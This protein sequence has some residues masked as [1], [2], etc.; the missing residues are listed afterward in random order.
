MPTAETD[1][2]RGRER[3][4][5]LAREDTFGQAPP[6]PDWR[7][8]PLAPKGW[9]VH[10]ERRWF[11]PGTPQDVALPG[12]MS[13]RGLFRAAPFPQTTGF[14]LDAALERPSPEELHSHTADCLTPAGSRRYTG[15]TVETLVLSVNGAGARVGLRFRGRSVS[16]NISLARSDFDYTDLT[17][18]PFSL[19]DAQL[20]INGAKAAAVSGFTLRADNDLV[21][22]PNEGRRTAY[23]LAR[24][25]TLTLALEGL[26]GG[27]AVGN[28]LRGGSSVSF[29]ADFQHPAGHQMSIHLPRLLP[30]QSDPTA[31]PGGTVR[32]TVRLT[33][34][35]DPDLG[36]DI[37]WGVSL[38]AG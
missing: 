28:A 3:H 18:T 35:E 26:D 7:C 30:R 29:T 31:P 23:L 13:P 17:P 5:R 15:L 1:I 38:S 11:R 2:Y 14:M 36:Y 6:N 9:T 33:A 16:G 4:L 20:D 24:P 25:R 21:S 10:A 22:G 32:R 27:D 12:L 8:V 34:A 19:D 37:D